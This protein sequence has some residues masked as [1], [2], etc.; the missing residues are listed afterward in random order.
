MALDGTRMVK[1]LILL[2]AS[3][4]TEIL[5]LW[6]PSNL[7]KTTH[8]WAFYP[9]GTSPSCMESS[10][11]LSNDQTLAHILKNHLPPPNQATVWKLNISQ[12]LWIGGEYSLLVDTDCETTSGGGGAKRECTPNLPNQTCHLHLYVIRQL[13]LNIPIKLTQLN[14]DLLSSLAKWSCF[15]FLWQKTKPRFR[16]PAWVGCEP[17][18]RLESFLKI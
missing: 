6:E 8:S 18:L 14:T 13:A 12:P 17:C 3:N 10:R 16:L 4:F 7:S 15:D 2:E 11:D 5:I 1:I 9:I